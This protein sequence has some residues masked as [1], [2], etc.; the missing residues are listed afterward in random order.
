M[1][2][3]KNAGFDGPPPSIESQTYN[4][5]S[6]SIT[7]LKGIIESNDIDERIVDLIEDVI[8]LLEDAKMNLV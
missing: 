1:K 5:V 3:F 4:E 8:V 2:Y 6:D 7:L